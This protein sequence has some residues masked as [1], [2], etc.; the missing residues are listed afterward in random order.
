MGNPEVLYTEN[1][2]WTPRRQRWTIALIGVSAVAAVLVVVAEAVTD[3]GTTAF[4]LLLVASGAAALPA[5]ALLPN[6]EWY[7]RTADS[8]SITVERDRLVV[9]TVGY[10][11][12]MLDARVADP[13]TWPPAER[14][15]QLSVPMV[16]NWSIEVR[17]RD[18]D[19][20]TDALTRSYSAWAAE[21]GARS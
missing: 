16:G 13:A 21:R 9:D 1:D 14:R 10:P 8:Q 19:A 6:H 3:L 17:S 11:F 15:R 18:P 7:D 2:R 20:F 4:V 5:L 12:A